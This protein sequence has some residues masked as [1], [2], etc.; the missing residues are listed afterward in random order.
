MST[1]TV[2]YVGLK[3]QRADTVAGTGLTWVGKGDRHPV[4]V[5]AW[6]KLAKHPDV[7]AL[8]DEE[9][10]SASPSL[11]DAQ[12]AGEASDGAEPDIEAM[13]VDALKAYAA[14]KQIRLDGRLKSASAI[15]AAITAA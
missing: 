12:P 4:P 3:A 14:A 6:E 9:P 7:W 13:D 11:A 8:V 2:E 15:R 1:V 10:A 5:E